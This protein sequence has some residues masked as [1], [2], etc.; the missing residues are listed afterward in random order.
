M[1]NYIIQHSENNVNKYFDLLTFQIGILA[2][3]PV[4]LYW[5]TK[6]LHH[7]VSAIMASGL[8][9]IREKKAIA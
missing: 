5:L 1:I 7:R 4:V 8:I 9:V 6:A 2:F 3:L